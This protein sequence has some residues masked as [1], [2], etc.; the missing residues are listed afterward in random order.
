M[1][2]GE[3]T[4]KFDQYRDLLES[5]GNWWNGPG[6]RDYKGTVLPP[7]TRTSEALQCVFCVDA[8]DDGENERCQVCGRKIWQEYGARSG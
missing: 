6:R 3:K 2:Q 5:W 1:K 7:L 4:S 8:V